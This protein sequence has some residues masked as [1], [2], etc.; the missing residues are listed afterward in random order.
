MSKRPCVYP[1]ASA[2][3]GTI[4]IGV[5]SDLV[6]RLHQHRIDAIPGFTSRYRMHLLVRFEFFAD[7]PTTIVREKQLKRWHRDGKIN[8]IESENPDWIDLAVG[9]G[10]EPIPLARRKNGS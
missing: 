3:H 7:M 6:A 4:Y 10:L 9:L 5:T 8:Q 2:R 1:L